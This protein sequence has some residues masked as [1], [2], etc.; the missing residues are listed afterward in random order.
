MG[1]LKCYSTE[2]LLRVERWS[3]LGAPGK[4]D[5]EEP[6][7]SPKITS[8][9]QRQCEIS[10]D[11][12][13]NYRT[14]FESRSSAGATKKLPC[15]KNLRISSW[16]CDME[17]HANKMCGAIW[18]G[19]KQDDTTTLQ[20]IYSMHRRPPLRRIIEICRRIVSSML[21]NCS[22]MLVFGTYWKTWY[23]MV[24][25]QTCTIDYEMDQSLW[26]TPESIDFIYSSHMWIQTK[27][28]CG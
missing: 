6:V 10:K 4:L 19:G 16:S 25:K 9:T 18:W 21:S 15:S 17:G 22:E 3:P 7:R 23:S 11:V 2:S 24:S 13:D 12:V 8:G 26:Q 20:S 1:P 5:G 14:M 28:S 27:V